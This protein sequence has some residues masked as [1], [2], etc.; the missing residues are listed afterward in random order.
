MI[1]GLPRP[2][3]CLVSD[4]R[5]V[6]PAGTDS[7]LRLVAHAASAGVDLIH[8]RE[9]DLDDRRLAALVAAAVAAVQGTG[10]RVVVNDRLDVALSAGAH[11]VHLRADSI[12]ATAVR[13]L[14]P[15]GFLIGRSIHSR[16]EAVLAARSGVDFLVAGTVY[17]TISKPDGSPLLGVSGLT[18]VVRAV[19]VP[20][21][22]IGGVVADKVWDIAAA[23]AAGVAAIGL[24]ADVPTDANDVLFDRT[25]RDLIARI[26]APFQ[27]Q[28]FEPSPPPS[29]QG[30]RGV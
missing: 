24:F 23:G 7:L 11:G 1:I 19:D 2:L 5:R 15:G 6:M 27:K 29:G 17:P 18:E 26:R 28:S 22:A 25:L 8:V 9:P 20:V 16:A 4:R 21:L 13:E 12:S 30:P 14:A 3:L 10:A